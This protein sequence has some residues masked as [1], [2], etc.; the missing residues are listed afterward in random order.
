MED[1][2][3]FELPEGWLWCRLQEVT[4]LITDGKHG[5]SPNQPNSG[6]YFLSAK[7]V[8]DCRLKL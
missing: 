2:I 6:Y 3:P 4:T 7:D 8:R 5:D 1:E